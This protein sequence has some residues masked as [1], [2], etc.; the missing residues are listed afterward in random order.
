MTSQGAM[1]QATQNKKK[2]RGFRL[3]T[4]TDRLLSD[5]AKVHGSKSNFIRAAIL[6]YWGIDE[7][8][9]KNGSN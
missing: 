5:G 8:E 7:P 1:S 4:R 9:K 2:T 3:D 6:N